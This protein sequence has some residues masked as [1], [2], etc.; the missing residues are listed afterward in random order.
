VRHDA[1]ERG[2][3]LAVGALRVDGD[4]ARRRVEAAQARP[5]AL[6]QRDAGGD[7]GVAAER[8]LGLGAEVADVVGA[9]VAGG[10]ESGLAVAEVH[11]DLLHLLVG[12]FAC[13]EHD[14]G[15]VAAG[16]GVR[17]RRVA[18]DCWGGGHGGD[19]DSPAW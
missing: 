16:G 15:G 9:A 17:E 19:R 18:Q 2:G 4:L 6:G 8:H 10:N 5:V 13:V 1:R 7:R 11:R 3:D 14:A 12:H